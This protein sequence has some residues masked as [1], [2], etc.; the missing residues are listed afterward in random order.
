MPISFDVESVFRVLPPSSETVGHGLTIETVTPYLKDYDAFAEERPT[1][2]PFRFDVS[3]WGFFAAF[4]NG[5]RIGGAVV[6][7]NTPGVEMLEGRHDL[8]CL[9]DIRVQPDRLGAGAGTMLFEHAAGWSR[10]KG[11][12]QLKIETQNVNVPACRFYEKRGCTL[13]EVNPNAYPPELN[14]IQ[15]LWYLEL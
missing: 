14:E 1:A 11:C 5:R 3:N 4:E 10:G 7:W 2:W 8:A 9:W 12:K 13:R 15:L 6:A